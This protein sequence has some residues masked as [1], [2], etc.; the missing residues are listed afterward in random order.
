[1]AMGLMKRGLFFMSAFFGIIYLM[2]TLHFLVFPLT[3][4]FFASLCDSQS[5]R[6]RINSGEHVPDNIDD[7]MRFAMKYKTPLLIA[8]AFLMVIRILNIG[9]FL[10]AILLCLLGW[11]FITNRSGK[12][13][14]KDDAH[15][16]Y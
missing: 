1:M 7:I 5:K 3:I 4:L 6:R 2:S 9:G 10:L 8:L 16:N 12:I 14:K 13:S 15:D 11:Y